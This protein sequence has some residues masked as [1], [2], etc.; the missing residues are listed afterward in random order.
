MHFPGVPWRGYASFVFRAL[1]QVNAA[2]S[3]IQQE[4]QRSTARAGLDELG[5]DAFWIAGHRFGNL[6]SVPNPAV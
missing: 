2:N 1:R 3:G 5:F 6:D 4:R